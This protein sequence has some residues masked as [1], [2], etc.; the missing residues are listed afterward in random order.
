MSFPG[1]ITSLVMVQ[2]TKKV[3]KQTSQPKIS[4]NI[5]IEVYP[6]S[7][8]NKVYLKANSLRT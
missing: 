4:E 8:G 2:T 1:K 7:N 5:I 6:T 3:P